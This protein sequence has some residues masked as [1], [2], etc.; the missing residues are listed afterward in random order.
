MLLRGDGGLSIIGLGFVGF[1]I[2]LNV[3]VIVVPVCCGAAPFIRCFRSLSRCRR[4]LRLFPLPRIRLS[5]LP[6]HPRRL[7]Y[8]APGHAIELA[9][10]LFSLFGVF[11]EEEGDERGRFLVCFY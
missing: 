6:L 9:I 7:L 5:P 11:G 4:R 10:T 3:T 8:F 1:S 2:G